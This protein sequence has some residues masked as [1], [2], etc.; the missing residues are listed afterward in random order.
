MLRPYSSPGTPVGNPT[1]AVPDRYRNA[2]GP[3]EHRVSRRIP[4]LTGSEKPSNDIP[5]TLA[6]NVSLMNKHSFVAARWDGLL[7]FEVQMNGSTGT[8][9]FDRVISW[10]QGQPR[11][12][13]GLIASEQFDE[14]PEYRN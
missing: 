6:C 13:L 1:F 3:P 8:P 14:P 12:T 10:C 11:I 4:T 5:S 9:K 2:G 7:L